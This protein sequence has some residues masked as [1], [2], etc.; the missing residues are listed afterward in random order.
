M[1]IYLRKSRSNNY[2]NHE[3]KILKAERFGEITLKEDLLALMPKIIH[4]SNFPCVLRNSH[5]VKFI[6]F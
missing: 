5:L 2:T 1:H 3:K 6:Y 4:N